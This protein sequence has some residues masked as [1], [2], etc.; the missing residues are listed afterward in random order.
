M[1]TN[2]NSNDKKQ[3]CL[4]C[5]YHKIIND[6]DPDNWFCDDDVAVICLHDV[7]SQTIDLTSNY[8]SARQKHKCITVA[9][10]PYNTRKESKQPSWCPLIDQSNQSKE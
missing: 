4:D 10:R 2:Q 5:K 9:C 6:P 1:N 8:R 3:N 7:V